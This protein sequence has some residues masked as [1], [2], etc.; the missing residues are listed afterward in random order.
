[1][2]NGLTFFLFKQDT[3]DHKS[4]EYEVSLIDIHII[5]LGPLPGICLVIQIVTG[6]FLASSHPE[7]LQLT[8]HEDRD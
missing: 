8:H 4:Y 1:M 7:S 5:Y 3:N 2:I 6:V